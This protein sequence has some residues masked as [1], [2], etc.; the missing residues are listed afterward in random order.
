M[1]SRGSVPRTC[2]QCGAGFF[3]HPYKVMLGEGKYCSVRCSD[4]AKIL[5]IPTACGRQGCARQV[6]VYPHKIRQGSVRFCSRLCRSAS[7]TLPANIV[8]SRNGCV[9]TFRVPP[10]TIVRGNGKYC[11][12][13]CWKAARRRLPIRACVGCG[14]LTK[15][16]P[17]GRSHNRDGF[18]S[19]A[20][21]VAHTWPSRFWEKVV[22][23]PGDGCW[24]WSGSLYWSGYGR[25]PGIDKTTSRKAHRVSWELAFGQIVEDG[26]SCVLHRCDNRKCVRP[27]HL[28]L[29]DRADNTRDAVRKGRNTRGERVGNHKLT[30]DNVISMREKRR[31]GIG[32]GDIAREFGVSYTAA[33]TAI[34]RKSW[35]HVP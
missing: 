23:L 15:I 26:K 34:T 19:R 5:A 31:S 2:L 24:E 14:K 8:C 20:C 27:D 29:G 18:C 17:S 4:L 21:K 33:Y 7:S 13:A 12:R 25:V 28:F 30:E 22:K 9:A 16:L 6:K 35:A 1:A 11:S 10:S 3:A 32:I